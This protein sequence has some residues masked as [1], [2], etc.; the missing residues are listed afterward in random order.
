Y[1]RME[2][3]VLIMAAQRTGKSGVV[4]DRILDHPGPVLAT[5]TRAD[6]YE[7][8][9]GA[10]ALRGPVHVFNPQGVGGV[11]SSLQWDLL[12]PCKDL[13]IAR[14]MASWLKV[15]DIGGDLKWFQDKGDVALMALLWA[16]AVTGRTIL[17]VY[18]WVQ[19]H[20]HAAC[21]EI[22][23]AHPGSNT[24][25]FAVVKR[26]FDDNRTSGSIRDTID[27]TLSW[28][29]LPG[30]AETVSP[31]PGA[32]FSAA[33][34]TT[35]LGTL[36]LI[37]AGDDDSPVTPLFRAL[38]SW[39]HYEAG[40]AGSK[41]PHKRLDPPL[42][43]ALDEVT[44][45]CP[46][47]LPVMLSDS[48]GKGVLITAVCH[49]MS[50]L[51]QRW[52]KHGAATVWATCGTKVLLGAISDPETLEHASLLCGTT[53]EDSQRVVP[54]ELLRMLPDWR[55][56]V[57][58]MNLSPVVV[59]VRPAWRRLGYRL[60]RHPLLVPAVPLPRMPEPAAVP[61]P[62]NGHGGVPGELVKGKM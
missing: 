43:M 39:V 57:I 7:S 30:L 55:A 46:V 9:A 22:L 49:S 41:G 14:R 40:Q 1:A 6:L 23:A 3:Q 12:G 59:K 26:M 4:A 53:G 13:V 16:A 52:G 28:S 24:Q 42:L 17:D 34:F 56:L 2:D 50:Q 8:T 44:Q 19:R 51:E 45:V 21:L 11:P 36:Y 61:A 32:G 5:S 47:D 35:Q 33:A 58:R 27:L 25:M 60:G 31:A 10:R 18:G 38:A 15:P 37:A 62:M 20:D 29:V 54:P 48:A